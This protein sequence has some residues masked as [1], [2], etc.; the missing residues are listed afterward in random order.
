VKRLRWPLG[1]VA[2]MVLVAW[3]APWI[4]PHDPNAQN[5][6]EAMRAP[7]T[8]LEHPL[9]T[10]ELGRD[11][12]S[13]MLFG[14]RVSL[15]VGVLGAVIS[16]LIGL[17]LGL[18]AGLRGGKLEAIIMRAVEVQLALPTTLLALVT[19]A[20][21]GR[22]L[23]KVIFVIGVFGWAVFARVARAT[24]LSQRSKEYVLAARA[25]GVGDSRLLWR[26]VLPNVAGT[27]LVQFTLDVPRNISLEAALS[28]LGLGVG[29]D[30]PSLGAMVARG[31]G[32]LFS[33]SWWLSLL[34][35]GLIMVVVL[36]VN[37]LADSVRYVLN[38][39]RR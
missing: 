37:W 19:L 26:H 39:K 1:L 29:L 5:L 27:L 4:T 24:V 33:G 10:D 12:L 25:L 32:Y 20:L 7:F 23:E 16:S 13:Q 14:L 30:T 28:F 21:L 17:P 9:G 18:I 22:G 2:I 31:Q 38:P 3:L 11:A 34:P 6:L 15:I 35:G 36:G 8:D